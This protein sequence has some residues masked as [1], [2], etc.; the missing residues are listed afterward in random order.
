MSGGQKQRIAIARAVI[1]APRILLLDEATS[2]LD[3]E[4][5]R[6]VQEA[7]DKASVGRT[8]IIIAHRLSTIRYADVIAV[9]Q[10]GHVMEIGP[11]DELMQDENDLYNSLVLLQQTEKEQTTTPTS[12]EMMVINLNSSSIN[13][14]AS[15]SSLDIN[16]RTEADGDKRKGNVVDYKNKLTAPSFK[17]LL[18]LNLPEWKQA[19]LGCLSAIL[20]G[21]VQPVFAFTV[22]SMVYVFFLKDHNEIKEKTK[23]YAL[24]FI[25]IA[26]FSLLVDI[27]Q[28]Y[29]FSYM[30]EHLTK[31][32]R[33]RMFSKM[34]TFEVGWFDE[35]ENSSGA[36][37]SRLAQ[38]ANVVGIINSY[39]F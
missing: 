28:H 26:V 12:E 14:S 16:L 15:R 11:H 22:G 29:N 33:E 34:L 6:V 9:M 31:R 17:R 19:M 2:A 1:K 21:A 5:E 18:A 25:G 3:S 10:N 27:S 39:S 30:G 23:I 8:T 35:D 20:S 4:S 37:C 13:A 7:L 36:I 32:T 24:S 38:D